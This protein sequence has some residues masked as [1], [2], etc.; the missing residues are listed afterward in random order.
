MTYLTSHTFK[1]NRTC[2]SKDFMKN[3]K[4]KSKCWDF[5]EG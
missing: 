1:I 5:L 3:K 2:M 4:E